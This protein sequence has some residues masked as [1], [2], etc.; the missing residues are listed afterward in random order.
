MEGDFSAISA[1]ASCCYSWLYKDDVNIN[2]KI[3]SQPIRALKGPTD[4]QGK[5]IT[6]DYHD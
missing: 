4:N 1:I 3:I 5:H 2:T 6:K